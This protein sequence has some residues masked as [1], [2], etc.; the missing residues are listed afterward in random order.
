M[1]KKKYEISSTRFKKLFNQ[2]NDLEINSLS[3]AL[4]VMFTP[5]QIEIIIRKS[6]G[7][8]LSKTHNEVFSRIIRKKLLALA[9]E[10]FYKLAQQ[11]IYA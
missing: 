4:K 10:K 11:I 9:N 7:L 8:H 6:G 1:N 2:I 3:S 5:Y